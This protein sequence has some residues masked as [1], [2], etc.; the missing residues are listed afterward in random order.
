VDPAEKVCTIRSKV[1]DLIGTNRY[2][3][4]FGDS[5]EF[6]LEGEALDVT[7]PNEF[8]GNWISANYMPHLVEAARLVVGIEPRVKIRVH[9]HGHDGRIA[10]HCPAPAPPLKTAETP[11]AAPRTEF[12]P[13]LRGELATFVVGPANELAFTVASAVA[14]KPGDAFKH[15]VFHGGCGLGKTHL[16]QGI[17]N[18]LSRSHPHL[19]WHYCSGEEFTNE[20]IYAVKFGHTDRFR[21]RFRNV[22]VLV[23]DDI[24]FFANKKAT[25][26]EFL[27]TFNAIDASGKTIVLSSDC[28][29][30]SIASLSEPLTDRLIA[31]MVV[32]VNPPDFATRR[33]ILCRRAQGMSCDLPVEVLDFMARSITRNVRELEGA[34]YKL[35]AFASLTKEKVSLELAH[36]VVEDY[37]AGSHS[38]EAGEIENVAL[39]YFGV[40]REALHSTSRD[41]TVTL[42][43]SLAMFLIRR[44][45]RLSFPEIGR[46]MG[47][48]QH[49]TVLMATRRIQDLLDRDGVVT[50]KTPMGMR[51][52]SA[53]N[54]LEELERKL[55]RGRD[56][57]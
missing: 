53:R 10:P 5:T 20:Y 9:S 49:S 31:A 42:A 6:Q 38:P 18:G 2:R 23:I 36:K 29:P 50:W 40:T 46:M 25:Q 28:H 13:T 24:H 21:A 14:R 41:R 47:N 27:H 19:Q 35:V 11:R 37:I 26:E 43:R 16:L 55:L 17:C 15:L 56:A 39:D 54:L 4:W 51:D 7:V 1:A 33:E 45:T 32:R 30:R 52:V 22:D 48:K 8:V 3:T 57:T 12:R 34:L 44:H